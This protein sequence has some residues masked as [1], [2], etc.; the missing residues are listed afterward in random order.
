[1]DPP[2]QDNLDLEFEERELTG[3]AVAVKGAVGVVSIGCG[4]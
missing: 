2:S 4:H 1:M 3:C